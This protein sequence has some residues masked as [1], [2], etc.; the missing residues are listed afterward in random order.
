MVEGTIRIIPDA[1]KSTVGQ[2]RSPDEFEIVSPDELR[3]LDRGNSD[4]GVARQSAKD[5]RRAKRASVR[6]TDR[7]EESVDSEPEK[8]TPPP[9]KRNAS[10]TVAKYMS[11]SESLQ[12]AKFYLS[13][14]EYLGVAI[15]G[16]IGEMTEFERVA[17][18]PA[19]QRS[20]RRI[21]IHMLE[22]G[23]TI[24][25]SIM[26]GGG[27]LM[28]FTRISGGIRFRKQSPKKGV[29]EDMSAPVSQPMENVVENTRAGD[30]DGIAVP[31]PEVF[32]RYMN[33]S[34]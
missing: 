27:L 6:V 23:N 11:D 4:N 31:V 8:R 12:N 13:M 9:R 30:I 20:L 26:L 33:G 3:E 10:V 25:D 19:L 34:I 29:S 14:I 7:T 15:S 2:A 21:P 28:Y 5:K 1:D 24:V 17:M 18:T 16:P 22:R 32:T